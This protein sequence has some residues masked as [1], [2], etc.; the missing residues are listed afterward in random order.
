MAWV[1]ETTT[2]VTFIQGINSQLLYNTCVA[3]IG[4]FLHYRKHRNLSK[5]LK[6]SNRK[7]IE[8]GPSPILEELN[9]QGQ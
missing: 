5:Q 2:M 8:S 3:T 1:W 6:L 9:P 4:L 7:M